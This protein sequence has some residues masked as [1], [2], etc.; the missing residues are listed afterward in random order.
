MLTAAA[1]TAILLLAGCGDDV[2]ATG[3]DDPTSS[4]TPTGEPSA[5]PTLP[6]GEPTLPTDD[7][8]D[9]PTSVP[10]DPGTT[11]QPTPSDTPVPQPTTT[12]GVTQLTGFPVPGVESGC[13][14]L[15]GYLLLGGDQELIASGREVQVTGAVEEGVMTTCQQGTPFRVDSVVAIEP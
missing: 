15:D 5:T 7:P 4:S 13:W 1:L 10:T 14:L 2:P 8:T 11:P 12:P 6:T 9:P 3:G